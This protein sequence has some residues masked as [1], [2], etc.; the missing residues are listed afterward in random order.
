MDEQDVI[1]V[2]EGEIEVEIE[3][4]NWYSHSPMPSNEATFVICNKYGK[5][6]IAKLTMCQ[7]SGA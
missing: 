6:N 2:L 1:P 7:T 3:K 5:Y 4:W